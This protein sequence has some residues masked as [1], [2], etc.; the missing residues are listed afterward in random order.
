MIHASCNATKIAL[1]GAHAIYTKRGNPSG[2]DQAGIILRTVIWRL[3]L[4]RVPG[5]VS[6]Q[7]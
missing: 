6:D 5:D 2:T 1:K 4:T 3:A 7:I